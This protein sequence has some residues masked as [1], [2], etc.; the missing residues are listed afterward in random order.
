MTKPNDVILLR[1]AWSNRNGDLKSCYCYIENIENIK[2]I[3]NN[4][5]NE[6]NIG[7]DTVIIY[8]KCKGG[9]LSCLSPIDKGLI[10][11]NIKKIIERNL[12][13]NLQNELLVDFNEI[14]TIHI[15]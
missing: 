13:T 14:D 4:G 11:E 3:E 8:D 7:S 15:V 12:Q 5:I 1:I 2:N 10:Y 9:F 6:V